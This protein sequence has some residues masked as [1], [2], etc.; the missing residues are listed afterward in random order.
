MSRR[1]VGL[2]L[3]GL[4]LT[5]TIAMPVAAQAQASDVDIVN[6]GAESTPSFVVSYE[7]DEFDSLEAWAESSSQFD[8]ESHDNASNIATVSGPRWQVQTPGIFDAPLTAALAGTP[9]ADTPLEGRSYIESVSPNYRHS[10]PDQPD[11][12][13]AE[14]FEIPQR[15]LSG[16][17]PGD[18]PETTGIAFEANATDIGTVNE[19]VGADSVSEDGTGVDVAVLDT[20]L[21]VR[22]GTA[23]PLYG[24]RITAA[25]NFVTDEDAVA[26]ND[27]E[28]VSDG[29]GHGSWVASSLASNAS[30][31]ALQGVAPDANLLIGKTLADDGSGSTADII[32]GIR[33][34]EQQD[35]DI[36]SMSLGS[37]VYD[38]ALADAMRDFVAGNGTAIFVAVGNSRTTRPAQIASPSDVPDEGVVGVAAT[39][40]SAPSTAGPA[41]FS[42]TGE[43]NG[44][45]DGSMGTTTGEGPDVAAVGMSVTVP[46]YSESDIR[47]NSTLS[48]TSMATPLAV[49]VATLGLDANPDLENETAEFTALVKNTTTA[50]PN[51]GSSEVGSGMVNASKLVTQDES[52]ESQQ[53]ART[54]AA[55]SRDAANGQTRL[56]QF[57]ARAQAQVGL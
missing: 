27:F 44:F 32:N 11:G 25:R 15:G 51:A 31:E 45:S 7:D 13:S 33:W 1:L 52:G 24:D 17:L 5:S 48:G 54:D 47:S 37:P 57:L 2:L 10:V 38:E 12:L 16:V 26:S 55:Q 18:G 39:N 23:D 6:F 56:T 46:V 20:G 41:Y 49:G 36:L 9:V 22:N 40:A 4:M 53:D 3:V 29:D 14:E 19:Y 34:A 35:A 28:N 21:N 8:I 42:Q 30:N 50:V 43:D